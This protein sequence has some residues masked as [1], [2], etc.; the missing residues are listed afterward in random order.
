MRRITLLVCAAALTAG[1][2]YSSI[3]DGAEYNG[4]VTIKDMF[5][6]AYLLPTSGGAILFDAGF[7]SSRIESALDEQGVVPSDVTDVFITH[8]HGDHVAALDLFT[9][10]RIR[11]MS[12]DADLVHEESGIEVSH[13]LAG[14]DQVVVG[15]VTVEAFAV[16]GHT[17]GNAVYLVNRVLVLGDSVFANKDGELIPTP[18]SYS[19]DSELLDTNLRALAQQLE[20]RSETIEWLVPAHTG[21]VRGI[22]PLL[23][24]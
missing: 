20:E 13:P 4:L 6:S 17:P 7:R 24:F 16:P 3:E 12:A 14:G 22:E 8:G 21:G 23:A 5:T 19:D 1:C 9:D 2:S 18:T 11:A 15:D 10:A